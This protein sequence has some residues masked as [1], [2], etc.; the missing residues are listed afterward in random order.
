MIFAGF[1]TKLEGQ[2]PHPSRKERG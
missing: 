2:I 1:A